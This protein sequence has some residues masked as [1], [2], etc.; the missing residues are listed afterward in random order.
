[1]DETVT[2]RKNR[3]A[4]MARMSHYDDTRL[5]NLEHSRSYFGGCNPGELSHSF[6]RQ[7]VS[8]CLPLRINSLRSAPG[9]SVLACSLRRFASCASR[10][11]K[12]AVCFTRRRC[13]ALSPPRY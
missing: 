5:S 9:G 4:I 8:A 7:A 13:T 3:I 2:A 6:M 1:V 10:S 11:P 12:E